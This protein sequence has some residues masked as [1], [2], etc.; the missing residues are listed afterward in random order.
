MRGPL[1]DE[2]FWSLRVPVAFKLCGD[3][4]SCT[5]SGD[6]SYGRW[7]GYIPGPKNRVPWV[8]DEVN[9]Q[10]PDAMIAGGYYPVGGGPRLITPPTQ[11]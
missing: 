4:S 11:G 2:P 9:A 7:E 1:A 6:Q 10:S 8:D 3:R 5:D